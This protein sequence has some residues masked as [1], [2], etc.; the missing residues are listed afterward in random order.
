MVNVYFTGRGQGSMPPQGTLRQSGSGGG[1]MV[2]D[3]PAPKQEP[4]AYGMNPGGVSQLGGHYGTHVMDRG[5]KEVQGGAQSIVGG[6][7]YEAVGPTKSVPG[8][9]GG[10]TLYGQCGTVQQYGPPAGKPFQPS[11]K[12]WA[13]PAHMR[14]DNGGGGGY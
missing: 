1:A 8:P 3:R 2:R 11:D 12:G 10:R 7:G 4:R 5:G 9:G 13:V 6:A 14:R